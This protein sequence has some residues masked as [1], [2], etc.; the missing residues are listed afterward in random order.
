M[1]ITRKEIRKLIKEELMSQYREIS[2][3]NESTYSEPIGDD[4][5]MEV[6]RKDSFGGYIPVKFTKDEKDITKAAAKGGLG[7]LTRSE[8]STINSKLKALVTRRK[9]EKKARKYRDHIDFVGV[10]GV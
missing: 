3:I 7:S 5:R 10:F 1:K 9:G 4:I 2:Q 8:L 6:W